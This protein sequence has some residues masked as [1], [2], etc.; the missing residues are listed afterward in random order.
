MMA[1]ITFNQRGGDSEQH[2]YRYH[3]RSHSYG[4]ESTANEENL[5]TFTTENS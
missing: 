4:V 1:W 3:F 5:R 2:T